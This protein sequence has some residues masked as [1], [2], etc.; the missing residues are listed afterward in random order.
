MAA[1]TTETEQM[2]VVRDL[3]D[4]DR[5]SGNLLERLVFNNRLAMVIV[6]AL[7]TLVLGYVAATRLTLNASFEKMIPQSQP[8]IKNYLTYQKDLRGLG[9]AIR[10]VV[11][12]TD[13]DIFDPRYLEALKQISDELILTPG[14]DRAWVKSLWTPAVRWTEVTE[15]GFRGGAGDAGLVQ[16]L[17]AERRAV[18]AEHR[19]LGNRRQPGRQRF[20]VEHDLRAAARQGARHRQAHRLPRLVEGAGGEDPRQVRAGAEPR[21]GARES[22]DAAGQGPRDRLREAD[23][24][25]DRRAGQ[26][27]DVLRH[28]RADRHRHHLRVYALRAQ[29]RA[30]HRLLARRGRLA[31]GPRRALRLRARSVLDPGAVPGVRDRRVARR[32]ED[33]RHHAGHRPRHA[34]A[35]RR[36]LHVPAAVPGRADRAA[37]RR[38]GLRR[39]DGHRHPGDPRP[40]ADREHRRRRADLHQPAAVAGAAVLHRR[41]RERGRAQPAARRRRRTAARASAP[42]WAF[43]DRFTTRNWAIGAIAVSAGAGGGGLRRLPAAQDRRPRSRRA[44]A[45]SRIRATTRTTPTSPRTT[46]CPRTSSR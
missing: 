14:V 10:V 31:A 46:R 7:V 18:E 42:L 32:A 17:A 22:G 3:A 33:E 24:R 41:Q 38:G 43:L 15:E 2:P 44:G 8:Y 21:A 11:E 12:N 26:G 45:A 40:R 36:A 29:H 30:G 6:C 34:Q 25:A 9:N 23:R 16:R 28:R 1:V 20:Q 39:A 13:G 35:R 4:F 37:R 19:A 27:D 5:N